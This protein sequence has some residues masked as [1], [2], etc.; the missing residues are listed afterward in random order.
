MTDGEPLTGGQIVAR[1]LRALGADTIFSVSGN[2]VLPLFD[3]TGDAGLRIIHTR[4]ESAAAYAAIGFAETTGLPGVV[5]VSAGPGFLAA[6]VGVATAKSAELPLLF[7]A[8]GAA[9]AEQGAGGFQD[10]DQ[11]SV[12]R[13][14]CKASIAVQTP[15]DLGPAILHAWHLA[16][17]SVPGPVHVMLPSDLLR[18][19]ASFAGSE[20]DPPPTSPALGAAEP[21]LAAMAERLSRATRPLIVARPSAGRGAAGRALER[22]AR[23]LGIEPVITECPRGLGDLKY[24]RTI[25]RY[26]ESDCA[27]VLAPADFA[28]GF[29]REAVIATT[30]ALL[31]IDAPGDPRPERAPTLHAQV[32]VEAAL[33]YLAGR[34]ESGARSPGWPECASLRPIDEPATESGLGLH[35]LAVAREARLLLSPDDVVVLD[36]GEYCQWIRLGLRDGSNRVLWNGKLGGIGGGL[37]LAL[38]VAAGGRAGRTVAFVGDGAFGYHAS[39]LETAARYGLPLVVIVGNDGRWGAEWH[40]Q[41]SRYGADRAF[42]TSLLAARYDRV[43]EG[44]DALGNSVADA[45]SLRAALEAA[46]GA[47]G[48]VCINARIQSIRSPAITH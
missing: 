16:N 41:V 34:V 36:G 12:A 13:V 42:E 10:L 31:H 18:A 45:A 25:A 6:G 43:A 40:L 38:G 24:E 20:P 47:G 33:Q 35:P 27:L 39:E 29:L 30:G 8:G 3:A 9:T 17:A 11:A 22:L 23:T 4:H 44:L 19:T 37:P 7:L 2:Q 28:V 32:P 14:T 15:A 1:T 26:P 21:V 5:L 48:P 46:L